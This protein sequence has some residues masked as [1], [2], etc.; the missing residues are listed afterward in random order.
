M[1]A[2]YWINQFAKSEEME[3]PDVAKELGAS[4]DDL[5]LLC[6][7]RTPRPDHFA[8][9]IAVICKR[10]GVKEDVLTRILRQEQAMKRWQEKTS[11]DVK[12]W[13]LAAS[14]RDEPTNSDEGRKDTDHER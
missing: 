14:D 5:V 7:C 2:G 3:W 6:L 11:S 1:W 10:T 9:D 4:V 13:L 8:E 12:G